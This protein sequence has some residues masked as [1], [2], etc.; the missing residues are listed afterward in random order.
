[1][2]LL[3]GMLVAAGLGALWVHGA[4]RRDARRAEV[5]RSF[6]GLGV[7]HTGQRLV[8]PE[9]HAL[10]GEFSSRRDAATAALDRGGWAVIVHAWDRFYLLRARPA[11]TQQAPVAFRSRAVADVVPALHD[12]VA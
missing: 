10:L 11:R 7:L 2:P 12:H 5:E 6:A 9:Q 8:V 1:M 3:P 4:A